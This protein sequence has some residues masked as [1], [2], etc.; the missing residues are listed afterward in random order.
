MGGSGAGDQDSSRRL[1]GVL[2]FVVAAMLR[3]RG[4]YHTLERT[5]MMRASL[6]ETHSL[7]FSDGE[8]GYVCEIAG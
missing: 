2:F 7:S 6:V 5:R 8:I 3:R 4:C 1:L